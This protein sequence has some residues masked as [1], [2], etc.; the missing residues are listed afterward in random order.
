MRKYGILIF[1]MLVSKIHIKIL[2]L[3]KAF[4]VAKYVAINMIKAKF[5][6]EFEII[7]NFSIKNIS[8]KS[9]NQNF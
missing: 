2:L 9:T 1:C 3:K 5:T 4:K 7:S 6:S 8:E